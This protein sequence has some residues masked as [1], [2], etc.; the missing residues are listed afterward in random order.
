MVP[1]AAVMDDLISGRV[2]AVKASPEIR[3]HQDRHGM[4]P[5]AMLQL[6]WRIVDEVAVP[7]P[8]KSAGQ[9]GTQ[10]GLR[11]RRGLEVVDGGSA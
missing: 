9:G 10:A 1:F 3:Q 6:R 7:V 2:D 11:K 8:V 5:K 4:N